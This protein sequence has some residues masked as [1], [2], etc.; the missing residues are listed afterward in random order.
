MPKINLLAS[1]LLLLFLAPPL[2]ADKAKKDPKAEKPD[3]ELIQGTWRDVATVVDGKEE[4]KADVPQGRT[5]MR[6]EPEGKLTMVGGMVQMAG[7]YRLDPTQAPKQ[8]R[9]VVQHKRGETATLGIYELTGDTLRI[10][11]RS[12]GQDGKEKTP[13][14]N[15]EPGPGLRMM[16]ME[17]V[18]P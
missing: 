17:R 6:F 12:P 1:C 11:F 10:A 3:Q 15:F 5:T 4:P 13:P 18:K 8:I 9:L 2:P 14:P 7:S 16:R